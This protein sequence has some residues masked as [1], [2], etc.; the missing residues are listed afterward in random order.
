[1][2]R[3]KRNTLRASRKIDA[4]SS[5]A[6]LMLLTC[7]SLRE[8]DHGQAGED[9]EPEHRVDKRPVWDLHEEK[10]DAE[11]DEADERPR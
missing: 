3:K 11:D 8:V 5:G 10:Y 9:H 7:R 6:E 2:V 4:A 1:M